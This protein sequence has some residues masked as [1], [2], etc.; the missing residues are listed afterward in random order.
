MTDPGAQPA[1][2]RKEWTDVERYGCDFCR[3]E[4]GPFSFMENHQV[5]ALALYGQ[6]FGFSFQDIVAL[7][8]AA[9]FLESGGEPSPSLIDDLRDIAVRISALLPPEE[10]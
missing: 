8:N 5:A 7:Y 1:L 2:S 6:P 9:T 10:K 4:Y 3:A